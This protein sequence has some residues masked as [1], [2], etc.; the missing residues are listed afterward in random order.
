MVAH[1]NLKVRSGCPSESN[2]ELA[3]CAARKSGLEDGLGTALHTE[4][5]RSNPNPTEISTK[6]FPWSAQQ[7]PIWPCLK[8]QG[9]IHH[10]ANKRKFI[11]GILIC[12]EK[13]QHMS[14]EIWVTIN[15]LLN[16]Y[17][18]T[19][20][21]HLYLWDSKYKQDHTVL[22]GSTLKKNIFTE[23]KIKLLM[24]EIQLFPFIIS[25]VMIYFFTKTFRRSF[26]FL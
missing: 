10:T 22:W 5:Y 19:K 12:K 8:C 13:L 7:F 24:I 16:R 20:K 17:F 26:W 18:K 3:I 11:V 21:I 4:F 1:Q 14:A 15:I 25:S 23:V 9:C 2:R 6:D